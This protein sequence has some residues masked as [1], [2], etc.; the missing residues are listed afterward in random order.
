MGKIYFHRNLVEQAKKLIDAKSMY[1]D[2]KAGQDIGE[3][4]LLKN[5]A[6]PT[7]EF[8]CSARHLH[9]RLNEEYKEIDKMHQ[10][11]SQMRSALG[12]N[13]GSG[14]S[15]YEEV[16]GDLEAERYGIYTSI[17]LKHKV[18]FCIKE[19]IERVE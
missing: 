16:M 5:N 6:V 14:Q 11:A 9:K 17:L 15:E 7:K 13:N 2:V 12:L 3:I 1:D 10:T 8:I 18:V 4:E 19:F